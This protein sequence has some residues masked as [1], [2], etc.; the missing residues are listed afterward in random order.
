VYR[1]EC[2]GS[3]QSY[4]I[5]I[6]DLGVCEFWYLWGRGLEPIPQRYSE[7]AIFPRCFQWVKNVIFIKEKWRITL[8]F[9]GLIHNELPLV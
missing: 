3:M 6:R 9:T 2:I 8:Q 7:T 4:A 1:R 5:Y